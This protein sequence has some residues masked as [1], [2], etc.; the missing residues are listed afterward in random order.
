MLRKCIREGIFC[1]VGH[2][3]IFSQIYVY[4]VIIDVGFQT[5]RF[6]VVP[7]A[8]R[9][10]MTTKTRLSDWIYQLEKLV[11][12]MI[13]YMCRFVFLLLILMSC[14]TLAGQSSPRISDFVR[15]YSCVVC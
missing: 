5:G 14:V 1:I 4:T 6:E 7:Q 10:T 8:C 15:R 13:M 3:S 2:I 11:M 12:I 9:S